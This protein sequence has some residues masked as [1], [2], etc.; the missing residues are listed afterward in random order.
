MKKTTVF[1]IG[2]IVGEV[3]ANRL[4]QIAPLGK[5]LSGSL[6]LWGV[7]LLIM[8]FMHNEQA[9]LGLRFL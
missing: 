6:I 4:I 3:P 7:I 9:I 8:G 5:F 2:I 1:W